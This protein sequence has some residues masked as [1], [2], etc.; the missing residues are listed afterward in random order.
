MRI[1]VCGFSGSGKSTLSKKLALIYNLK[2]LH[3]DTIHFEPNWVIRDNA[4]LEEDIR[5]FLK[6][7]DSWVID[8]NYYR[9]NTERFDLADKI[10]YL[11][12]NRFV[13]LFRTLFRSI[14]NK[15]LQRD[16]Q[17]KGCL[18]APS[19]SFSMWVLFGAR[20]KK[21]T[22]RFYEIVKKYPE[23]LIVLKNKKQ[24]NKYLEGIINE[25]ERKS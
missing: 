5:K 24:L 22:N 21:I 16:D 20:R 4:L 19:F 3:I 13:C 14:K 11:K 12:F 7:N 6:E 10:I 8:G 25:Q 23:K 1:Q 2:V 17:A 15:G 9:H 18:D